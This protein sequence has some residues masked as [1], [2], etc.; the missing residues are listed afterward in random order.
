MLGADFVTWHLAIDLIGAGLATL[1]VNSQVLVVAVLAW[2]LFGERPHR[3]I[4]A[5][6][7]VVLMGVALVS[8]LGSS[9]AFGTNPPASGCGNIHRHSHPAGIDDGVG[10]D[11]VRRTTLGPPAHRSRAG[12]G[13]GGSDSSRQRQAPPS[14]ADGS[15]TARALAAPQLRCNAHTS[16]PR[17][18]DDAGARS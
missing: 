5:V 6:I 10:G 11:P 3:S 7:P 13:G 4:L 9:D 12:P 1:L 16:S 2:L 14:G 8:G 15:V 18:R 17:S